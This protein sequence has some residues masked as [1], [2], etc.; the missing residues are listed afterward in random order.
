MSVECVT[1]QGRAQELV[2]NER[3]DIVEYEVRP[4]CKSLFEYRECTTC[5]SGF[6]GV[7]VALT[8]V[9]NIGVWVVLKRRKFPVDPR[10][11]SRLRVYPVWAYG[12]GVT[13]YMWMTLLGYPF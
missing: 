1:S 3:T 5:I 2:A 11:R 13:V 8:P 6:E 12:K 10:L 9:G 7:R 4:D